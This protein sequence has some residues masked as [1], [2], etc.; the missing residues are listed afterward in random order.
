MIH[1][2]SEMKTEVKERLRG[3]QGS[4]AFRYLFSAEELG[5]RAE[6]LATVTLEPGAS[7][8][9]HPHQ[10]NGEVYYILSG[11]AQLTEDGVT[12]EI[13]AGD[14]EFCADGHT[15]AIRNHTAEA[16]TFLALIVKDL[17]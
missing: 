10:G 14:A 4:P 1:Q 13:H 5:N 9:E 6:M 3:G 12:R 11:A 7:I 8:G 2:H 16:V 15:H 17:T